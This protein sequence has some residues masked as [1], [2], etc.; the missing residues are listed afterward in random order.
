M[1]T[2]HDRPVTP[3]SRTRLA[4][5][6]ADAQRAKASQLQQHARLEQ[7][8]RECAAQINA[9]VGR[10]TELTELLALL[11]PDGQPRAD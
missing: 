10:E 9:L 7:L 3:V 2:Q 8:L 1:D 6:L 5:R 4:A 11:E